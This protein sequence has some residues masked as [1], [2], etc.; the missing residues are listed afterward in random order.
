MNMNRNTNI[1]TYI[2]SKD[3]E[4]KNEFISYNKK[5]RRKKITICKKIEE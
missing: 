2:L 1:W 3:R 5:E 4:K